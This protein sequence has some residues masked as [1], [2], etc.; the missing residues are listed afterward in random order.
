MFPGTTGYVRP[1]LGALLLT[2]VPMPAQAAGALDEMIS[3]V[4]MPTVNEDPRVDSE[5]RPMYM[6]TKISDDFGYYALF[7][8]PHG[9]TVG[10]WSRALAD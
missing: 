7:Q 10:L 8:D 4:S 9:N 6:Y 5:L 1:L 3:P 2:L